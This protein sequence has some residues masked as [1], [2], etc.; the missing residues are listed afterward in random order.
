MV[1]YSTTQSPPDSLEANLYLT[2]WKLSSHSIRNAQKLG[3]GLV[4]PFGNAEATAAIKT[5]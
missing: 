4:S 2:Q 1:G 5:H 3:R